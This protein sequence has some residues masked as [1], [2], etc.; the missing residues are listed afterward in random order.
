MNQKYIAI[1]NDQHMWQMNKTDEKEMFLISKVYRAII[2]V[3]IPF[4]ITYYWLLH[5]Y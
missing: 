3:E 5:V 4:N 1:G 2:L